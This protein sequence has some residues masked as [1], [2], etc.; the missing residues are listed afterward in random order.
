MKDTYVDGGFGTTHVRGLDIELAGDLP[1]LS[2][3]LDLSSAR[4]VDLPAVIINDVCF[5]L[6]GHLVV[7][8]G[9]L[10]RAA[11]VVVLQRGYGLL[12]FLV[13]A[14]L[15]V[16]A[17]GELVINLLLQGQVLQESYK[18]EAGE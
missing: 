8:P 12:N 6:Q 13:A 2:N 5:A 17:R 18:T 15:A 14:V 10:R 1:G 9:Q 3:L 11:A 4:D 7:G 16:S